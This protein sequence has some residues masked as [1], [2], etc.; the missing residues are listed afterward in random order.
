MSSFFIRNYPKCGKK[1]Q[2]SHA[3]WGKSIKSG[4]KLI[5][6]VIVDRTGLFNY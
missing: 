6:E 1:P 2:Q 4:K 3:F 5:L